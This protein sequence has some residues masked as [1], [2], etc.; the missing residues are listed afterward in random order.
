MSSY[1]LYNESQK[2][3]S[4]PIQ[5]LYISNSKFEKDW[6]S[7][8]HTH[9]C[10][11]LFYIIS[12]HGEF[13]IEDELVP[14]GSGDIIIINSSIEHTESSASQSPMEYIVLGLEGGEFLLNEREDSG[15]CA[16]NCGNN[17]KDIHTCLKLMLRELEICPTQFTTVVSN[18]LEILFIKLLRSK[19]VSI[20]L[21][22][23]KTENREC[24]FVKRYIDNNY[25]EN[26]TLEH[27]AEITHLNK[28]YMAHTFAKEYGTSPI[29]YMIQRRIEESR[30]YLTHTNYSITQIAHLLGFSSA[31]YFTQRF[32]KLIEI[33]PRQYRK[34]HEK[35]QE[36]PNL[37]TKAL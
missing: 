10:A 23:G 28:Y 6:H 18:L 16:F 24:A 26:I 32:T 31:S 19:P 30:Y 8:M 27:L 12:G 36:Q 2:L 21:R 20:K 7:T 22:V 14:A 37:S 1:R 5:L 9:K 15:Y 29:N 11:E 25:M 13:Q 4:Y 17:S 34:E 33:S 35:E 3:S